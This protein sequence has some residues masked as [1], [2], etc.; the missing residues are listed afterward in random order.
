MLGAETLNSGDSRATGQAIERRIAFAQGDGMFF[1]IGNVR[2]DFAE[3]PDAALVEGFARC[4][5][6]A[7]KRLQSCRIERPTG[8]GEFQEI[9]AG[10]A[11][12]ILSGG[13]GIGCAGDA[14]ELSGGF[15]IL[16][17]RHFA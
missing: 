12:E 11:T 14:A 2:E 13:I 16:S 3:T 10:G 9:A 5:A 15:R 1:E 17:D 7:P 4:A 8:E 6:I